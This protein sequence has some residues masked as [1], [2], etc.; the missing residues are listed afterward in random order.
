MDGAMV[1]LTAETKSIRMD[2]ASFQTYVLGLE[3][4]VTT[5]E[6]QAAYFLDRD[7]E[8]LFL[9]SKLTDLE[10]RSRRDNV[11]F[12]G[13]P[14]NIEGADIHAFL[15]ETLPKLTGI[16]FDPPLDFQRAH[17]LGP[18]RLNT[19]T[20]PTVHSLPSPS[21]TSLPTYTES[22]HT[23]SLSAG[24]AHDL[25]ISRLSPRKPVNVQGHFWR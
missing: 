24:R 16:T 22:T 21:R 2:V 1:S 11:R 19:D 9:H 10:D 13:F 4:R 17:W 12:I 5:V 7:Q 20:R 3:Q 14:E 18:W 15:Q 25:N 6:A 8:L 23:G